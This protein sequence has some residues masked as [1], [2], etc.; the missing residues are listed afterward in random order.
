MFL[1]RPIPN[2]TESLQGYTFRLAGANGYRI[3]QLS[4]FVSSKSARFRSF[5]AEDRAVIKAY[6]VEMTGHALI[7]ELFDPWQHH[8]KHKELFDY[9]RIK[10]CSSCVSTSARTHF[11]WWFK[12][13][14]VCADHDKYLIDKCSKCFTAITEQGLVAMQ[15][16]KCNTLMSEMQSETQQPDELTLYIKEHLDAVNVV[17]MEYALNKVLNRILALKPYVRLIPGDMFRTWHHPETNAT[18]IK[19][20]GRAHV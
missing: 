12:N 1:I 19:E 14:L 4:T 16:T 5:R 11:L 8:N 7:N 15:C 17:D 13:Y 6:L 18:S 20:I 2:S 9:K 3:S 10:V